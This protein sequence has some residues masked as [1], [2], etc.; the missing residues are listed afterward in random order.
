MYGTKSVSRSEVKPGQLVR[1]MGKTW[2]A[3]AN[4]PHGLY[5]RS[6]SESTRV[7]TE[8]VEIVITKV[9]DAI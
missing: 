4:L 6:I 7:T 9:K 1:F 3:S 5:L 8:A 2:T